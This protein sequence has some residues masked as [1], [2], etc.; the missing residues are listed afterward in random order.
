MPGQKH[1]RTVLDAIRQARSARHSP[2]RAEFK[3]TESVQS[4]IAR[5]RERARRCRSVTRT[6]SQPEGTEHATIPRTPTRNTAKLLS[7]RRSKPRD[8]SFEAPRSGKQDP[9]RQINDLTASWGPAI[10]GVAADHTAPD[11]LFNK[12]LASSCG[13]LRPRANIKLCLLTLLWLSRHNLA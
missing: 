12:V 5:R 3:A 13:V 10:G 2:S 11:T 8:S 4:W 1:K 7:T 9:S 6:G